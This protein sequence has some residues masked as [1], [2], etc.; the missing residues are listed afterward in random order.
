MINAVFEEISETVAPLHKDLELGSE[1]RKSR[2][3]KGKTAKNPINMRHIRSLVEH[4]RDLLQVLD[5]FK[6]QLH[7]GSQND[8]TDEPDPWKALVVIMR[9]VQALL[10]EHAKKDRTAI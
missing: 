4:C 7:G 10:Q 9:I 1:H 5:S 6:C 3:Q 8:A 2:K